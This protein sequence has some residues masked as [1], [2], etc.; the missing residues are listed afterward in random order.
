M[1]TIPLFG[2]RSSPPAAVLAIDCPWQ[3]RDQLP[4]ERGAAHKYATISTDDLCALELPTRAERHVLFFW[5]LAS[6]QADAFRVLDAWGYEVVSELVWTKL[7]PCLTCC[8][9]GSVEAWNL[10]GL[11]LVP[12]RDRICPDCNGTGGTPHLGLGHYV[13]A[14]HETCLIARPK[15]GRAPE[16]LDLG[17]PSVLAAPMLLDVDG[18]LSTT[19]ACGHEAGQ[20][21]GKLGC[22]APDDDDDAATCDCTL[23]K[24]R[25]GSLVHSAKPDAFFALVERMYPG[26]RVEMFSRRTR[27]GWTSTSSDQPDR[28]DEV[29]R[30]MR[31]VWPARTREER[32]SKARRAA[33]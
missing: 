22:L 14:A 27:P 20:H 7:R 16:R 21:A 8:A 29:A 12:G 9:T 25:K 19:C 23:F 24:P 4:G 13:R 18:L 3:P 30:I 26:P 6:M 33:R 5:R 17:I 11:V 2:D 1:T 28:L 32:L 31:E 10:G 15:R